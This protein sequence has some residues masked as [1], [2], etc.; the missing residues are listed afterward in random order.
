MFC[1]CRMLTVSGKTSKTVGFSYL[2]I[3]NTL[4][5]FL[6]IF[7]GNQTRQWMFPPSLDDIPIKISMYREFFQYIL[8]YHVWLLKG[9]L[10]NLSNDYLYL[11]ASL[12][13]TTFS[14]HHQGLEGWFETRG[15]L[16]LL[17]T[18][19]HSQIDSGVR[20]YYPAYYRTF[21]VTL[22]NQPAVNEEIGVDIHCHI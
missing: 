12:G 18:G 6:G 9:R 10:F 21:C 22:R 7:S 14:T 19:N 16:P 15:W 5:S 17:S 11:E 3:I 8:Q 20:F 13:L 2:M 1:S 4:W